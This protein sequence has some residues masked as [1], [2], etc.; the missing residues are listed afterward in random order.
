ML[1][2]ARLQEYRAEVPEDA[3]VGSKVIEVKARDLDTEASLTTYSIVSGNLLNAFRIEEQT[4]YIRVDQPLDYE[5]IRQYTLL[6]R[7]WDGQYSNDTTVYIDILN[8]NDLRPQFK[9]AKYEATVKEN[10]I[11]S[12]PIARYRNIINAFFI[13]YIFLVFLLFRINVLPSYGHI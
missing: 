6:V 3:D 7:A 10:E 5:N 11:P 9:E 1:I 2:F 4:G 8:V 12:Y 13:P